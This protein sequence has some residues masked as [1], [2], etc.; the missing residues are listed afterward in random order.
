MSPQTRMSRAGTNFAGGASSGQETTAFDRALHSV[1]DRA[2]GLSNS[3]PRWVKNP[4][5]GRRVGRIARVLGVLVFERQAVE[6]QHKLRMLGGAWALEVAL[7]GQLEAMGVSWVCIMTTDTGRRLYA[8]LRAFRQDGK[9]LSL[10]YGV[11]LALPER[12]FSDC[13]LDDSQDDDKA[14]EL[15]APTLPP[16]QP[17]LFGGGAYAGSQA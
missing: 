3:E 11:Q 9:T 2:R 7:I 17:S 6:S 5:T 13:V 10:R 1:Y 12:F 8:P 4:R 16:A 14:A 15:P